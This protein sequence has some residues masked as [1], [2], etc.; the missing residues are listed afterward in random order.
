[1][2]TIY[3]CVGTL[4]PY[5]ILQ[6][7]IHVTRYLHGIVYLLLPYSFLTYAKQNRE[8]QREGGRERETGVGDRQIQR[9]HEE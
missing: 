3:V 7:T 5:G 4:S 6:C 2:G 1:M 8:T 9:K